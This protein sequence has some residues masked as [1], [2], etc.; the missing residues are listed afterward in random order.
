MSLI[1][2]PS[3]RKEKDRLMNKKALEEYLKK[4]GTIETIPEGKTTEAATMKYKYR[5]A[6]KKKALEE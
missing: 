3:K 5:N 6:R 1:R 2:V 4:G